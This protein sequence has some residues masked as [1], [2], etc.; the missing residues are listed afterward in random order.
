MAPIAISTPP[1]NA[2]TYPRRHYRLQVHEESKV[3]SVFVGVHVR[4]VLSLPRIL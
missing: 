3:I 4:Y 1:K 2:L